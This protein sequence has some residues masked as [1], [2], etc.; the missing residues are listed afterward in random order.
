MGHGSAQRSSQATS[1]LRRT[2]SPGYYQLWKDRLG[3]SKFLPELL[4]LSEPGL[5]VMEQAHVVHSELYQLISN[6][7]IASVSANGMLRVVLSR[8]ANHN[9]VLV[10][11]RCNNLCSFCS[12]PPREGN[13]DWLL[14]QAMLALADFSFDGVIGVSGGEPL[15][16]GNHCDARASSRTS[17]APDG[18][19]GCRG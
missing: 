16:Y 7:D 17:T 2:T 8:N 12:Q 15:L 10:T 5:E 19:S 9:T 13:D 6:G 11:E 18:S 4:I 1:A 3:G 14:G